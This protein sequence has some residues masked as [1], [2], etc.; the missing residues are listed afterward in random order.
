MPTMTMKTCRFKRSLNLGN[1]RS[2]MVRE[3]KKIT[4]RGIDLLES[5]EKIN[6]DCLQNCQKKREDSIVKG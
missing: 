2:E 5:S 3:I 6:T 4:S 1:L